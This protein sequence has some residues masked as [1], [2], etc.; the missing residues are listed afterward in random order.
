MFDNNTGH[1]I[2]GGNFYNVRGDVNLGDFQTRRNLT[3]QNRSAVSPTPRPEEGRGGRSPRWETM[4][5]DVPAAGS[6]R[7]GSGVVRSI[8]PAR[9]GPYDRRYRSR[10]SLNHVNK[11][12]SSSA[13]RHSTGDLVKPW[14]GSIHPARPGPYDRQYQSRIVLNLDNKPLSSSVM[15][16]S[17]DLLKLWRGS[18]HSARPRPYDHR[19]RSRISLNN[20]NEP[21]SSSVL[22]HSAGDLL[23]PFH[24]NADFDSPP[25]TSSSATLYAEPFESRYFLGRTFFTAANVNFYGTRKRRREELNDGRSSISQ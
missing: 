15:R 6:E 3:N 20:A 10:I 22:R 7:E 11:P 13:M 9:Q 5:L 1:A 12:L 19:F 17:A 25:S 2:H 16:H 21:L 4:R 14:R 24:D 18:K 23:K 8:H